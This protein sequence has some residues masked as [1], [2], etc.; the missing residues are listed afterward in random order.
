[1]ISHGVDDEGKL[2][3]TKLDQFKEQEP[4][5]DPDATSEERTISF[6]SITD[7]SESSS[8]EKKWIIVII[9]C[10]AMIFL[11]I[12]SIICRTIERA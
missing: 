9:V 1:M 10:S 6:S 2:D 12:C 5:D 11:S 4:V 3:L 7:D 8:L